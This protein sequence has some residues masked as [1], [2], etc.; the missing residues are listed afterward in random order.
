MD[1]EQAVLE[2]LVG[3]RWVKR[4]GKKEREKHETPDDKFWKQALPWKS[5]GCYVLLGCRKIKYLNHGKMK[6]ICFKEAG[7]MKSIL[8]LTSGLLWLN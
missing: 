6:K 7:Y 4:E 3:E 2:L 5:S 1:A 8:N